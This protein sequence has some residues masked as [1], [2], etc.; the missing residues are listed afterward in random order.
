MRRIGV[1]LLALFMIVAFSACHKGS[2]ENG[3]VVQEAKN[4]GPVVKAGS[5]TA[6]ASEALASGDE[7]SAK[8]PTISFDSLE[9]DFGSVDQ[10][11]KVEH[12]FKFKN[13][14]VGMLHIEKV[15]SS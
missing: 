14:G 15:R 13:T 7:N 11:T 3:K 12:I 6:E 10:G 8:A 2:G 1:C 4:G 9:Y 5:Q